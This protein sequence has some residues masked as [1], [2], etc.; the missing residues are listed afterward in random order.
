[1]PSI[2][3]YLYIYIYTSTYLIYTPMYLLI[4]LSQETQPGVP[5][6]ALG[7]EAAAAD[8][9]VAAFTI[10]YDKQFTRSETMQNTGFTLLIACAQRLHMILCIYM[11][12]EL[13][14]CGTPGWCASELRV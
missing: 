1:M 2:L 6:P 4:Y 14:C 10:S 12:A 9:E 13:V 11:F 5:R 3:I 7:P 8:A